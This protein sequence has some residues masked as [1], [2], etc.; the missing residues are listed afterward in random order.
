LIHDG[1]EKSLLEFIRE[2]SKKKSKLRNSAKQDPETSELA[3]ILDKSRYVLSDYIGE[4]EKHIKSVPFQEHLT[5]RELLTSR[6]QYYLYMI[7]FELAN[8][9]HVSRFRESKFKIALLPYCLKESHTNCKAAKDEIDYQCK[10][11]LKTCFIN[12]TGEV[13]RNYDIHP[14]I[15]SRGRVSSL[16]KSLYEK[17]G[18]LGV[19][20]I[21]CIVELIMG[22]RLC[23]KVNLPVIGIP[24]NANRCPRWMDSM[25]ET[26]L[27]LS[28]LENLVAADLQ[29]YRSF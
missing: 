21:A 8:R 20:G 29:I 23:M 24:L 14:Y 4:V 10:G 16:L 13:L 11:C 12:Q 25:H 7:E 2:K 1:K 28:A 27:D 26:S 5:D 22:M 15:L 18:S 6:E 9:M 17:H 3:H 19:L